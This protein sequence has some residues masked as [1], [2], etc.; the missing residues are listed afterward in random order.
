[1]KC[2]RGISFPQDYSQDPKE[3]VRQRVS[4]TGF[5]TTVKF[6]QFLTAKIIWNTVMSYSEFIFKTFLINNASQDPVWALVLLLLFFFFFFLMNRLE[7]ENGKDRLTLN[8]SPVELWNLDF[9]FTMLMLLYIQLVDVL[10][11]V[12]VKFRVTRSLINLWQIYGEFGLR[13]T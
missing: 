7:W 13:S 4:I 9:C 6:S 11:I 8:E 5:I 3:R 1:M 10:V 12:V 2:R